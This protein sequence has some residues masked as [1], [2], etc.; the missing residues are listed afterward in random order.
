MEP[1]APLVTISLRIDIGVQELDVV[2]KDGFLLLIMTKLEK[3]E[4]DAIIN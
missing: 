1:A 4:E 2:C 3:K